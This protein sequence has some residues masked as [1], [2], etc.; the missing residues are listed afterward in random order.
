MRVPIRLGSAI[1]V[2]AAGLAAALPVTAALSFATPAFASTA[3]P[4]FGPGGA[5]HAVFVQTD[6][7]SGNQVVAY[8]RAS[9][10]TLSPAGTYATGGLGGQLAGSVV[11]HLASQGSLSYDPG[12]A[13][14]LRGQRRER[15]R[16]GLRRARRPAARCAR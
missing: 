1:A 13:P 6:N 11:D 7:T 10:G 2:A 8:H 15:H 12:H 3:A 5:S 14:A 16:L 9:D 4:A